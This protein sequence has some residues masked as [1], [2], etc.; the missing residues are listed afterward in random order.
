MSDHTLQIAEKTIEKIKTLSLPADP[1]SY[2]LWYTYISGYNSELNNRIDRTLALGGTPSLTELDEIYLDLIAPKDQNVGPIGTKLSQEIEKMVSVLSDVVAATSETRNDCVEVARNLA[3]PVD[4]KSLREIA[5][6]LIASLRSIETQHATLEKQLESSKGE[7]Q[8][9]QQ[10]LTMVAV[11][12]SRDPVTGLANRRCFDRTMEAITE[13]AKNDR[14]PFSL[15]MIDIDHFKRFNDRLGHLIGDS[16]LKLVGTVLNQSAREDDMVARFGGEEFAMI[17]ANADLDTALMVAER[18]RVKIMGREMKRRSTGENLGT[19]TVSIGAA[20][21]RTNEDPRNLIKRADACLYEAKATG[22][23][24]T[25]AEALG[26][27]AAMA[28]RKTADRRAGA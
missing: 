27:D 19:I 28:E 6:S 24:K 22:R 5:D 16:I 11:E 7:L 4:Q 17:L 25:C 23:N 14:L 13:R 3:Q 12:A 9:L 1:P 20:T 26:R 2:Q 8:S 18:V 21:Y 10:A 15:L